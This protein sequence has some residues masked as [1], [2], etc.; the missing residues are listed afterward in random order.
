MKNNRGSV[1]FA[2]VKV[3]VQ[4]Q[5]AGTGA[6]AS[7]SAI[8]TEKSCTG[9]EGRQRLLRRGADLDDDPLDVAEH[10]HAKEL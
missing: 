4:A 6:G 9:Q 3:Q 5:G 2:Q 10:N 1:T 7:A 8:A